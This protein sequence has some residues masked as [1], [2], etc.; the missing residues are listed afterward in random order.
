MLVDPA[1]NYAKESLR[2][3]R[4]P[5]KKSIAQQVSFPQFPKKMKTYPRSITCITPSKNVRAKAAPLNSW[6]S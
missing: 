3:L 5:L 1:L 4:F 6:N 2:P